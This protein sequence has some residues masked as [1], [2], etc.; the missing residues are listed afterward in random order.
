MNDYLCP[1]C[2][3]KMY[4]LEVAYIRAFNASNIIRCACENNIT[5]CFDDN[6]NIDFWSANLVINDSVFEIVSKTYETSITLLD[7]EVDTH[8][9]SIKSYFDVPKSIIELNKIVDGLLKLS[10]YQ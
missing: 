3:N 1:L 2:N 6:R 9:F 8:I 10:I 5:I 4:A 7:T